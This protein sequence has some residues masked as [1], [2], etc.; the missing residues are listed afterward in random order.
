MNSL[1]AYFLSVAEKH[2]GH[3][4]D[5][6]ESLFDL[7]FL[8]HLEPGQVPRWRDHSTDQPK[9]KV[10][11]NAAPQKPT[12][13]AAV[14]P[15]PS[16]MSLAQV[17]KGKLARPHRVVLYGP[18]GIGKSTFGANAPSPI[19][20]PVEDGTGHLDVARFPKA[21]SWKDIRD[22]VR[23]LITE[24]HA[25]E[26]F[27]LDTLDAAEALLWRHMVERDR[28][29]DDKGRT[30]LKDIEGYGFGKGYTKALEDWRGLLKDLETLGNTKGVH[31]ILLAHS[32]VKSFK[33]PAGEDYDRYE[34]KLHQKASGLVKEW[35]DSVLFANYETFAKKDERTKRVRG[36]DSGARLLFTERRAAYDAKHRGNLP[37]SLPLSWSDFVAESSKEIDPVAFAAEILRKA[38][39]LGEETSKL[40]AAAVEKAK[41]STQQLILINNRVNTRLAEKAAQ[42]E[43][44]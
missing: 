24:T 13:A 34:L 22:A 25:Y 7:G 21:E 17:K 3:E 2:H 35:A 12:A 32:Q 10:T 31:V 11:M 9:E 41:G 4:P 28:F 8:E 18:E 16:R 44:N 40:V 15:A 20:L 19:F 39:E 6:A 43:G 5:F 1:D 29:A 38:G 26:T 30:P 33:N 14:A 27:V 36:F 23:S 37:E 42:E